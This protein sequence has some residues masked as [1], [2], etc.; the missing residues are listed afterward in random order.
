MYRSKTAGRMRPF[1]IL[2]NVF[3][4]AVI[5][6]FTQA[7][8]ADESVVKQFLRYVYGADGVDISRTCLR[9]EDNWMLKGPKNTNALS[10]VD[11]LVIAPAKRSGIY[12]GLIQHDVYFVEVRDG[13]VDPAFTLEGIYGIQHQLVKTFVYAS[14]RQD[15]S[16]L[17]RL[18]TDVSK[19]EISGPRDAPPGGDMDVYEDIIGALPVVRSSKPSDDLISNTITYKVPVGEAGLVLTL[20]KKDGIWKIDTSKPIKVSLAFFYQ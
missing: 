5:A 2:A 4:L 3:L 18:V 17:K 8:V 13:I 16:L 20:L 9:A 19:V 11:S 14:L 1:R 6:F 7:A 10:A 12:S 15:K